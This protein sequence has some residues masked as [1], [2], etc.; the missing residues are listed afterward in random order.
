MHSK[1]PSPPSPQV[2]TFGHFA[3][4]RRYSPLTALKNATAP[5]DGGRW[6]SSMASRIV[7]SFRMALERINLNVPEEARKRLKAVA[8]R[9]GRT[10]TEVA[11]ELFLRGLGMAERAEFYERVSAE[12]TPEIRQRMIKIAEALERING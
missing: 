7:S 11:R 4:R 9:L 10:E 8:K 2:G 3:R 1:R 5:D 12:M 6:T